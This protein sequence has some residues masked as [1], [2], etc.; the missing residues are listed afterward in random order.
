MKNIQKNIQ[1]TK[2]SPFLKLFYRIQVFK[3]RFSMELVRFGVYLY[4]FVFFVYFEIIVYILF[5]L[6]ILLKDYEKLPEQ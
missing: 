6:F 5:I 2:Y 4:I 3:S 1:Y